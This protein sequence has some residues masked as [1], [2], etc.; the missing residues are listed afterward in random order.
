MTGRRRKLADQPRGQSLVEL[1]ILLPVLLF[2]LLGATDLAQVL[3]AEVHLEGAA[4]EAALS[5]ATTPSLSSSATLASYM[6]STSGLTPISAGA[7]YS[8]SGDG[9]DQVVIT[10]TYSYPLLMPGLR[11]LQIGNI[12]NGKLKVAVS[13][14]GIA[15]TSAPSLVYY[16]I[17]NTLTLSPA[18]DNT[19]PAGLTLTCTLYRNGSSVTAGS[20]SA[21]TPLQWTDPYT[22][23]ASYTATT[24]QV[25]GLAS[26]AS[27]SVMAP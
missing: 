21:G 25:N 9:A 1:A 7:T 2:L 20:C 18:T 24:T 16:S 13:A 27:A 11:N 12:S 4:H 14:S 6:Q 8:L 5:L 19:V 22:S 17:T 23:T 26:P 3:S 10:A 15:A